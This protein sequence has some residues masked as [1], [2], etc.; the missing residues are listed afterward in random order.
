MMIPRDADSMLANRPG[1]S[2][3]TSSIIINPDWKNNK[4]AEN[5]D[6]ENQVS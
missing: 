6:L 3:L 1:G 4:M 2:R 5:E